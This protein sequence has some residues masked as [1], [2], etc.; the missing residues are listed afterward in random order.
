MNWQRARNPDQKAER[1]EAILAAAAVLF[2]EKELSEISMRDVAHRSG[3]GKASL[4]HYFKTK[5]EVFISLYQSEL[6]K[7][8]PDV[9]K[10]LGRLRVPT[11]A[12]VAKALTDALRERERLCRL[13]VVFSSVLEHNLSVD[14]IREFKRSLLAPLEQLAASMAESLELSDETIQDFVFQHHATIA[15]LWPLAH[16]PTQVAEVLQ[17]AQFEV[18]RI[19]FYRL[20]ER[21]MCQLLEA[22]TTAK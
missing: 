16:P 20:F 12:R 10:R 4:Y 5:E 14:F 7:W 22:G 8:L 9:R 18:F 21:T 17:D 19:D 3:L 11:P 13:A 1:V 15:G 6:E 2:D